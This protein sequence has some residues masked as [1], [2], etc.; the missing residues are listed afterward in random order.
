MKEQRT[1]R[2]EVIDKLRDV[3]QGKLAGV[4]IIVHPSGRINQVDSG[5]RA[6]LM[7]QAPSDTE[8]IPTIVA[9]RR[10]SR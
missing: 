2:D 10:R 3:K 1:T 8:A 6:P 9:V 5:E 4:L 7:D